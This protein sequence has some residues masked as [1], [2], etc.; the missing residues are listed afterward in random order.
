M[1]TAGRLEGKEPDDSQP[2]GNKRCFQMSVIEEFEGWVLGRMWVCERVFLRM[3]RPRQTVHLE[4]TDVSL[5]RVKTYQRFLGAG[6][7]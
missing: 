5:C 6:A 2:E 4:R 7:P 3:H 1:S